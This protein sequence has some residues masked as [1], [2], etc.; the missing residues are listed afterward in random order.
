MP[1]EKLVLSWNYCGWG[2]CLLSGIIKNTIEHNVS[3]TGSVPVV[4]LR[5]GGH[6]LCW[7]RYGELTSITG[8]LPQKEGRATPV[9][10]HGEQ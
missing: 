3:E 1:L 4:G 9:T 8:P 5:G 7:F 10:G 2:F 6:L